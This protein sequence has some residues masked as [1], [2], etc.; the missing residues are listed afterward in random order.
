MGN[1]VAIYSILIIVWLFICI[2][3]AK[4]FEEIAFQKGYDE[5]IHSFAMCF[6]L[7]I[8]GY[9]Y[10]IALPNLKNSIYA[11]SAFAESN[12]EHNTTNSIEVISHYQ[13]PTC[14]QN[15]AYG[16]EKCP[17]CGQIFKWNR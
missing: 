12:I 7:G 14:K 10:V 4:K 5:S 1:I 16:I 15:I 8:V 9:L 6:W 17:S 2:F 13:C 3:V 11:N